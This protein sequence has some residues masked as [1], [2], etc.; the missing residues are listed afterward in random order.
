VG[1]A[2]RVGGAGDGDDGSVGDAGLVCA[3]GA[4][5][6]EAAIGIPEVEAGSGSG[7]GTAGEIRLQPARNN[8]QSDENQNLGCMVV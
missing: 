1:K 3:T 4:G 6:V 2:V 8:P 5:S 7:P